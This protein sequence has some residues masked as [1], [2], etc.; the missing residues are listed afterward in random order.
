MWIRVRPQVARHTDGYVVQS[1]DRFHVDYSER[2][3]RV[4]VQVEWGPTTVISQDAVG[5]YW[6]PP[7]EHDRIL[8]GHREEILRRIRDGLAFLGSPS[9]L[10]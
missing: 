1:A 5:P 9:K 6:E 3:R 8:D 4:R 7:H 2:N 10:V